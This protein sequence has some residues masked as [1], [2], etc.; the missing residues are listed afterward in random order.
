M[1]PSFES[2]SSEPIAVETAPARKPRPLRRFGIGVNVGFQLLLCIVLFGIANYLGYRHFLRL[3]LTPNGDYTLSDSTEGYIRKLSK[4][5]EITVVFMR[6]S[7]I[8][9]DVRSLVD[10]F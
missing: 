5:V 8:M 1:P 3:D 10:E 6:D 7:P 9:Q 2:S 4:D